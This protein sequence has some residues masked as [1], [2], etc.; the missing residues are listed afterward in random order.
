MR[1][2]KVYVKQTKNLLHQQKT[3]CPSMKHQIPKGSSVSIRRAESKYP[4]NLEQHADECTLSKRQNQLLQMWKP[5]HYVA[6]NNEYLVS[7]LLP[8]KAF[9]GNR[10]RDTRVISLQQKALRI[11]QC[12]LVTFFWCILIMQR[13]CRQKVF[14]IPSAFKLSRVVRE[15]RNIPFFCT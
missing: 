9:K 5:M 8:K 3:S 10:L 14:V 15:Y 1:R 12:H 7:S 11:H 6:K 4:R 13:F 2:F